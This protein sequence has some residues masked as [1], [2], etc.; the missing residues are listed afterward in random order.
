MERKPA[1]A[2]AAA[3][4]GMAVG[5]VPLD[6][7]LSA[8]GGRSRGGGLW[9]CGRFV[10]LTAAIEAERAAVGPSE[11]QSSDGKHSQGAPYGRP[12]VALGQRFSP[13]RQP[14]E[15]DVAV[16]RGG[17]GLHGGL[18]LRRLGRTV[19]EPFVHLGLGGVWRQIGVVAANPDVGHQIGQLGQQ[20]EPH[21][22]SHDDGPSAA[23]VH[24]QRRQP[25]AQAVGP[26]RDHEKESEH[27][28]QQQGHCRPAAHTSPTVRPS[29][30]GTVAARLKLKCEAR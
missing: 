28:G 19:F 9:P 12:G 13:Q 22:N 6:Q 8:G 7:E 24:H 30:A 23:L 5:N 16:G 17:D 15:R 10:V 18:G 1:R 4:S 21:R 29:M 11:S 26:G 2:T 25:I 3:S 27:Q 20:N 14:Q